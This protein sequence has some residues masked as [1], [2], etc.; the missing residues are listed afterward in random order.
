MYSPVLGVK[1]RS[2]GSIPCVP[3]SVD[4]K[5]QVMD[6]ITCDGG[7]GFEVGKGY[8][9][10]GLNYNIQASEHRTSDDVWYTQICV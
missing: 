4:M 8:L 9:S 6:Y 2:K 7:V 1:A 3:G 5:M 10:F